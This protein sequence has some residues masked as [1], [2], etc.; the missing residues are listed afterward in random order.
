[1]GW[2]ERWFATRDGL[3]V[4]HVTEVG[5]ARCDGVRVGSLWS[6]IET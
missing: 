1:M 6:S 4:W 3:G 5:A 2:V